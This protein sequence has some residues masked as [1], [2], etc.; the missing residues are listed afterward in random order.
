MKTRVFIP[1]LILLNFQVFAQ[2]LTQEKKTRKQKLIESPLTPSKAAFYSAV[3]PGL[4]QIYMGKTWKVPFVYAA[5]GASVDGYV[6]N[7]R[8]MD[9]I[10]KIMPGEEV[11][12]EDVTADMSIKKLHRSFHCVNFLRAFRLSAPFY[13]DIVATVRAH[14]FISHGS[15]F[16]HDSFSIYDVNANGISDSPLDENGELTEIALARG[17]EKSC[18]VAIVFKR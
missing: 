5:I 6:Y 3:L 7:Q 16:L 2:Q 12:A 17:Y 15:S 11:N 4:G 13:D 18:A 14:K 8:E 10:K 1:I 9:V